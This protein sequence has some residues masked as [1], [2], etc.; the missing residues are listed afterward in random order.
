MLFKCYICDMQVLVAQRNIVTL[1]SRWAAQ[2]GFKQ[3]IIY[4]Q[5]KPEKRKKHKIVCEERKTRCP[6]ALTLC[7][8]TCQIGTIL[9][10]A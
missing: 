9:V 1:H 4:S 3:S 8:V 6:G 5:R 2:Q 7:L 10:Y